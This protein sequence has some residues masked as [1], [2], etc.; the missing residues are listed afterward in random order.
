MKKCYK[1]TYKGVTILIKN[2][3]WLLLAGSILLA[4]CTNQVQNV[5]KEV[6]SVTSE[7]E[8]MV[9]SLNAIQTKEMEI[10]DN[11]DESLSADAELTNFQD[12][13]AVVFENVK[14]RQTELKNVKDILSKIKADNE[15]L[16]G[17]EDDSLPLDQIAAFSKTITDMSERVEGYVSDYENQLTKEKEIFQ[18]I[19]EKDADFDTLYNGVDAL[20]EISSQ[21]LET[22][23]PLSELLDQFDQQSSQLTTSLTSET[24]K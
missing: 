4:G 5:Q 22:L 17:F 15:D 14:T 16:K 8:E 6:D 11:F 20:N 2:N 9:V 23:R 18:S 12:E 3:K 19:G 10:Q 7:K 1:N 24:E 13:S 21:N